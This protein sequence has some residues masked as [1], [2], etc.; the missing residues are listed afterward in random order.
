[1]KLINDSNPFEIEGRE[2]NKVNKKKDS[3]FKTAQELLTKSVT[4]KGPFA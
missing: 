4:G 2:Q 3:D 1:M